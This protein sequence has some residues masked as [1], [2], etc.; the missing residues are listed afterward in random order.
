MVISSG[1]HKYFTIC[2]GHAIF[3]YTGNTLTNCPISGFHD[4]IP[5][6]GV[7]TSSLWP[8]SN[9]SCTGRT[10]A[11]WE[12]SCCYLLPLLLHVWYFSSLLSSGPAFCSL[13]VLSASCIA[14]FSPYFGSNKENFFQGSAFPWHEIS[15]G[16]NAGGGDREI[17]W[18]GWREVWGE[19][20]LPKPDNLSLLCPC[21][22]KFW[23][24]AVLCLVSLPVLRDSLFADLEYFFSLRESWIPQSIMNYLFG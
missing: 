16:L 14:W 20:L 17:R 13:S 21:W 19:W 3:G 9:L 15:P 23:R 7:A 10:L 2:P 24:R 18:K 11:A 12:D 22:T 8:L 1:E 5:C 4:C 6:F